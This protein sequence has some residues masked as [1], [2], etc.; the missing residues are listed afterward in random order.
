[1]ELRH[2]RYFLAV[3]EAG[4]VTRA[5][6]RLGLQQPPLSRQIRDLEADLG[7][8]LFRRRPRGVDLTAAGAV[9]RDEVTGVLAGLDDAV[10]RV[11]RAARGE[12]GRVV[13]GVTGSTPFHPMIQDLIRQ[14]H[15][16]APAI[17]LDLVVGGSLRLID[18]VRAER[19]DVAFIRSALPAPDGMTIRQLLA[20]PMLAALPAGHRLAAGAATVPLPLRA[21]ADAPFI[22]YRRS[23]GAGIYDAITA[24]CAA[25]G[26]TPRVRQQAPR[27]EATLTLVAAGLGVTLVAESLARLRIDGVVYRPVAADP[28]LAAPLRIAYR[29]SD[30]APAVRRF[31]ALAL[32]A[33]T[34]PTTTVDR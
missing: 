13:V 7:V 1:M 10:A 14:F 15:A 18:D 19:A 34:G 27:V 26:F 24:A 17:E 4:H 30:T 5:A 9:F 6:E 11:R 2:L 33:R 3:A 20:E 22:L 12:L 28:P 23:T 21:L 29:R 31:L 32:K 25:A 8:Q 16:D